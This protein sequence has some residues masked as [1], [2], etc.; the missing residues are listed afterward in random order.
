M[1]EACT[2]TDISTPLEVRALGFKWMYNQHPLHVLGASNGAGWRS[3]AAAGGRVVHLVRRDYLARYL[4]SQVMKQQQQEGALYHAFQAGNATEVERRAKTRV[5]LDPQAS[6]RELRAHVALIGAATAELRAA[7]A[8][9]NFDLLEVAY[10]DLQGARGAPVLCAVRAFVSGGGG[11]AC[12]EL[13]RAPAEGFLKI[14]TEPPPTY[15]KNWDD[16]EAAMR[17]AGLESLLSPERSQRNATMA[18]GT[19]AAVAAMHDG[20]RECMLL[21]RTLA[22]EEGENR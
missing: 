6:V 15:V 18:A 9:H 22:A 19:L 7:A 5:M 4:S 3:L 8:E 21:E 13:V 10:E 12:G 14:H 20:V 1:A 17:K 11:G 16:V 2:A